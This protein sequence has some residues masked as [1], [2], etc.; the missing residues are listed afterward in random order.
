VHGFDSSDDD[1]CTLKRL[2]S[3]YRSGDV[4]EV[5]VLTHQD[6]DASV[7]RYSSRGPSHR[8]KTAANTG[9]IRTAQRCT[10]E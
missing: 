4:V 8:R 1:S 2:Q 5:L 7:S 3:E 10:V 9:N 6:I